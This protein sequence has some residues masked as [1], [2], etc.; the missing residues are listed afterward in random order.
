MP[1]FE[2][3]TLYSRERLFGWVVTSGLY[4]PGWRRYVMAD[5]ARNARQYIARKQ[6][7]SDR[8]LK[9]ALASAE[10]RKEE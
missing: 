6:Q 7:I 10:D 2:Y 4:G 5:S 8:W 1:E 9:A 3:D